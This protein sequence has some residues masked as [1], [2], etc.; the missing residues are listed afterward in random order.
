MTATET[1][2]HA[3][4]FERGYPLHGSPDHVVGIIESMMLTRAQARGIEFLAIGNANVPVAGAVRRDIL[5]PV[6]IDYANFVIFP[7][8]ELRF[9]SELNDELTESVASDVAATQ[10]RAV[11]S[12]DREA[13]QEM[14]DQVLRRTPVINVADEDA[15]LGVRGHLN[16]ASGTPMSVSLL[17]LDTALESAHNLSQRHQQDTLGLA[18]ESVLDLTPIADLM[19]AMAVSEAVSGLPQNVQTRLNAILD[20]TPDRTP[21]PAPEVNPLYDAIGSSLAGQD[22]AESDHEG[23]EVKS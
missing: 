19:N 21:Q 13:A 1:D 18:D 23:P 6:L 16:R 12:K 7:Q 5:L 14:V 3:P 8:T 20:G 17:M 9:D 2:T 10:D 22:S 4:A 11:T 15:G